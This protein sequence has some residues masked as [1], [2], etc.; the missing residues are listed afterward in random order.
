[1]LKPGG[2]LDVILVSGKRLFACRESA[3][4]GDKNLAEEE[5]EL[6]LGQR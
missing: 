6:C 3:V 1:V 5:V 4:R 2:G